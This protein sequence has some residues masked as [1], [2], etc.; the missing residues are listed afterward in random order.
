MPEFAAEGAPRMSTYPLQRRFLWAGL[1]LGIV[2]SAVFLSPVAGL[3]FAMLIWLIGLLWRR[4][5]IPVLAFCLA[6]QWIFAT[7][8]YLFVLVA[9]RYPGDTDYGDLGLAVVYSQ[10]ALLALA[11]GIRA[12]HVHMPLQ[13]GPGRQSYPNRQLFWLV[14]LLFSVNWIVEISPWKIAIA[15]EEMLTNVLK[16]RYL[17][18][19]ALFF[20]VAQSGRGYGYASLAMLYVMVPE[21]LTGFSRFKE[22]LF[23]LGIAIIGQWNSDVHTER[24]GMRN[25]RVAAIVVG[26]GILLLGLGVLWSGAVKKDWR[27]A[28]WEGNLTGSPVEKITEFSGILQNATRE[29]DPVQGAEDLSQR[30]S[31]GVA[32]FSLALRNVPAL[33]PHE[34]GALTWRAIEHVSKPRIFFPDKEMMASDSDL[35]REFAGVQVAGAESGTSVGMSYIAEFYIDFGFPLMLLPIFLFGMLVGGLYRALRYVAKSQVLFNGAMAVLFTQHLMSYE[36]SMPKL[37]GGILQLFGMLVIMM[38]VVSKFDLGGLGGR[39]DG[40]GMARGTAT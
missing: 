8:G 40:A 27:L 25:M 19:F 5:A 21:V 7:L 4:D 18:L 38:L 30:L 1:A 34:H 14:V 13:T 15:A 35:V 17:F 23:L 12:A 31:S 6:Y 39:R 3:S 9:D 22:L 36:G 29:L 20:S 33:L 37:L 28:L 11:L 16:V 26:L 2:S 24:E 10:L 32:Y